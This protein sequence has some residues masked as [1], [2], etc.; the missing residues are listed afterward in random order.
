MRL[1]FISWDYVRKNKRCPLQYRKPKRLAFQKNYSIYQM[2]FLL[3]TNLKNLFCRGIIPHPT[4]SGKN[5][6][7][8][9]RRFSGSGDM[10]RDFQ[11]PTCHAEGPSWGPGHNRPSRSQISGHTLLSCFSC[12]PKH[13]R[14]SF[15]LPQFLA[16]IIHLAIP[17]AVL[18]I[19]TLLDPFLGCRQ[20]KRASA[21]NA[22]HAGTS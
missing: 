17:A 8:S 5:P 3:E 7:P 16:E 13:D 18:E 10:S 21:G 22:V 6:V 14:Q 1:F 20:K 19:R 15:H 2:V 9:R 12:G 4:F 11:D